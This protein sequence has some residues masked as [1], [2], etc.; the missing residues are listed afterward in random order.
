MC[1]GAYVFRCFM[2]GLRVEAQNFVSLREVRSF[3]TVAK[4]Q[5]ASDCIL[6]ISP[7]L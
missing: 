4:Q 1:L 3:H 6:D 2:L 5:M 7:Y